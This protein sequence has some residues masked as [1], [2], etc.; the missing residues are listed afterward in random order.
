MVLGISEFD[1][2]DT[3]DSMLNDIE[4]KKVQEQPVVQEVPKIKEE[5]K[6]II[7]GFLIFCKRLKDEHIKLINETGELPENAKFVSCLCGGY[8]IV[9]NWFNFRSGTCILPFGYEVSK[10]LLGFTIVVPIGTK[11]FWIKKSR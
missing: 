10:N 3:L 2:E 9:N 6:T 7:S 11:G 8:K 4:P 5:Q 1:V